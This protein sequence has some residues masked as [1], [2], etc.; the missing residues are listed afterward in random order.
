MCKINEKTN[1]G[2][3]IGVILF[4]AYLVSKIL[5]LTPVLE[6]VYMLFTLVILSVLAVYIYYWLAPEKKKK[7]KK[8]EDEVEKASRGMVNRRRDDPDYD[9]IGGIA[10]FS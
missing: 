4:L 1:L 2:I 6:Y 8:N 5:L 10:G 7:K 9:I 3:Y